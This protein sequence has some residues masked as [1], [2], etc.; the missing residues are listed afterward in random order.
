MLIEK[1]VIHKQE[2]IKKYNTPK[3]YF[4]HAWMLDDTIK[5]KINYFQLS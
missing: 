2:N 3:P 4:S 1:Y 5:P